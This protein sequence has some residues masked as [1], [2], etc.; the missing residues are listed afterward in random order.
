[1]QYLRFRNPIRGTFLLI[2][3]SVLLAAVL[4]GFGSTA[5]ADSP[6]SQ[7]WWTSA[8]PGN[9]GG[10]APP[11]TLPAPPD[12]PS[13]GI[14]VQ[15][16]LTSSSGAGD[17]GATAYG[18]LA[19]AVPNGATVGKLTLAVAPN[20]ATTPSA[21][22]EL[23]P[24]TTQNFQSE[25]GGPM[26]DAPSYNC[27]KNVTA[28]Q[29][30]SSYQFDVSSLVSSGA[31]TVAILPTSPTDRVALSQPDN[32][33]LQVQTSTDTTVASPADTG[34]SSNSFGS[35]GGGDTGSSS[36][37]NIPAG[38]S[39]ATSSLGVAA[40]PVP[41]SPLS[42]T[43]AEPKSTAN[44]SAPLATPGLAA[45]TSS[46]AGPRPWVGAILLVVLLTAVGLWMGAGRAATTRAGQGQ[47]S[48]RASP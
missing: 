29:A 40:T 34:S 6:D 45:S 35:T 21:T 16:G 41:S 38:T 33:S 27:S 23:C 10:V 30:S 26:S 44:Q 47:T 31:L 20:S 22:L 19:Y 5:K 2:A 48:E 17:S 3:A 42:P 14:L 15:G 18:A 36:L 32:Q 12:V 9:I 39:G 28:A 4:F 8:N 24:L 25:Q 7:G 11:A 13:N 43:L 1:M 46:G 37:A